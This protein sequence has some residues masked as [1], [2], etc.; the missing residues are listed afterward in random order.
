MKAATFGTHPAL[1]LNSLGLF[2]RGHV[3][4]SPRAG[5]PKGAAPTKARGPG[6]WVSA[7][8]SVP[9][10]GLRTHLFLSWHSGWGYWGLENILD[11]FKVTD[12][13]SEAR[14]PTLNSDCFTRPRVSSLEEGPQTSDESHVTGWTEWHGWG[15]LCGEV[16]SAQLSRYYWTSSEQMIRETKSF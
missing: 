15:L 5:C 12:L 14:A 3:G 10:K 6:A 9:G 1:P 11:L 4:G 2:H 13:H 7:L 8:L 16:I